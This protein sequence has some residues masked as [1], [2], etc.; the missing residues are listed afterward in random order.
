MYTLF[1]LFCLVLL[2]FP[3]LTPPPQG[4]MLHSGSPADVLFWMA[5]PI[6]ER[7]LAAKRVSGVE[8]MGG[9]RFV[10]WDEQVGGC[11]NKCL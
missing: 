5:H 7:L 6:I 10:K 2:L 8:T 4:E 11:F 9:V 3:N 1:Q